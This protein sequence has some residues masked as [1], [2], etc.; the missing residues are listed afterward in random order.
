MVTNTDR[1]R[2]VARV[3]ILREWSEQL[4]QAATDLDHARK[5]NQR[6]RELLDRLVKLFASVVHDHEQLMPEPDADLLLR[7][8]AA[9]A[10]AA[11]D[12]DLT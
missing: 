7:H 9:D 12:R 8:L 2:R 11:L 1:L 6:Y 10:I 5:E 3:P 4:V